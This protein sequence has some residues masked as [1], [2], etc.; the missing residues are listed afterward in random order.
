MRHHN[1]SHTDNPLAPR[2]KDMLL[3]RVASL[4]TRVCRRR[5]SLICRLVRE[6]PFPLRLGIAVEVPAGKRL[7]FGRVLPGQ[8]AQFVPRATG[9]V[10]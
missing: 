7:R 4:A 2:R 8:G 9:V 3:T 6:R 10:S 5:G 1:L